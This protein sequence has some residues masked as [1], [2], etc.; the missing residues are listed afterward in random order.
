MSLLSEALGRDFSPSYTYEEIDQLET[1]RL[2]SVIREVNPFAILQQRGVG[3]LVRFPYCLRRFIEAVEESS[4]ASEVLH[5]SKQTGLISKLVKDYNELPPIIEAVF[6]YCRLG[7]FK[8]SKYVVRQPGVVLEHWVKW[9]LYV[10]VKDQEVLPVRY[11]FMCSEQEEFIPTSDYVFDPEKGKWLVYK[12]SV[13]EAIYAIVKT[14]EAFT[15]IY[16][17]LVT[18]SCRLMLDAKDLSRPVEILEDTTVYQQIEPTS[19]SAKQIRR[20]IQNALNSALYHPD[21]LARQILNYA[22]TEKE[23]QK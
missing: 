12:A 17:D 4:K 1:Q 15:N 21:S 20:S 5:Y 16:S 9:R 7:V 2:E 6:P 22:T 19:N 18:M 13:E 14:T 3:R 23:K 8:G 11:Q 10:L